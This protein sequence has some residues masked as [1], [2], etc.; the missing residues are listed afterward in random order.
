MNKIENQSMGRCGFVW[1]VGVVE[2]RIDPLKL[3]R[4]RVRAL[5]WHTE[6]KS[7]IP[8]EDLFWAYPHNTLNWNKGMNGLG[9]SPNG[10]VE[11]CW[12]YGYWKDSEGCQDPQITN[13]LIGIPQTPDL[14]CIGF[15]DP[16]PPIHDLSS[17]P[18]KVMAR[19]YPNDGS[20]AQ[21]I[22]ESSGSNYPRV[23]HPWGTVVGESDTNRLARAELV[24]D[25]II[26][27]RNRQLDVHI[28]IALA[29]TA[30]TRQWNEPMSTYNAAYPYNNVYESES[31]HIV[32]I[33]DTPGAERIHLYHRSGTYMEIQGGIDGD[34]VMKVVGKRFEVT[35]EQSYS[36]FQNNCNITVDGETNIYCR[37]DAN[38]QIDGNLTLDVGGNVTEHVQGN[39]DTEI[40][41]NRTTNIG[42]SDVLSVDIDYNLKVGNNINE[43]AGDILDLAAGVILAGDAP[44][45]FWNSG[46]GAPQLP[47]VPLVPPFP[48]P[49]GFVET[50]YETGPDPAA[51][52]QSDVT[53]IVC[54][55]IA[56]TIIT[57]LFTLTALPGTP[58]PP[59]VLN[60]LVMAFNPVSASGL[61]NLATPFAAIP[62]G[63]VDTLSSSLN[64]LPSSS[65]SALAAS[66]GNLSTGIT[67]GTIP[68]TGLSNLSSSLS[69]LSP[70]ALSNLNNSL[71]SMSPAA[72]AGLLSSFNGVSPATLSALLNALNG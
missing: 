16:G 37:S 45:I 59:N 13:V 50:R 48:P 39:W 10:P 19:Y 62:S 63:S 40:L 24:D 72:I 52:V 56:S 69:N 20:G 25:T 31:G 2:D 17:S 29:H 5:G 44:Q 47:D 38:V 61:T 51:E 8:T 32:E 35:M 67:A 27:V 43:S 55:S 33:D 46:F 60:A 15:Q 14:P 3:G 12:V 64:T 58:L 34:F 1:F 54:A 71:A 6:D 49:L 7:L 18:R 41:G 36:H 11:G 66:L 9:F 4:L 57:A 22:D 28:P 30:P 23:T 42:G 65:L 70:A 26:G 68:A 21:L 53:P